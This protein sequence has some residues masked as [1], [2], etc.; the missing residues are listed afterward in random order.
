MNRIDLY[1][2]LLE[3]RKSFQLTLPRSLI[4]TARAQNQDTQDLDSIEYHEESGIER[5]LPNTTPDFM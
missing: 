4:N 5:L 1:K 2:L 3:I